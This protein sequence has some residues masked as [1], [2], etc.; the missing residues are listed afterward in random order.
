MKALILGGYGVFGGRL[1]RLLLRDG[2]D[3]FVGGR[4]LDKAAAFT[5]IHGGT[6]VAVDLARDLAPIS[7]AAPDIVVDAAG[8]FQSY[9]S[10]PY[11]VARFCL[12][13][14]IHYLDLSDDGPFTAG[15]VALEAEARQAGC[16]ALSGVSSVPAISSAAVTRLSDGMTQILVIESVILPGNRAPRGRSVVA[17]ILAQTGEPLAVWRGGAWRRH[18]AW[19][20]PKTF[21][22][23]RGD[24]RSARLIGAP[25]LVLF[26]QAFA[27]RSVIFR[28][29]LE[30]GVMQRALALLGYLRKHGV[31]PNLQILTVPLLWLSNLLRP[32]GTDR[33]G[34]IVTVTGMQQGKAVQRRWQVIAEAGDGPFVPAVPARSIIRHMSAIK[35]GARSCISELQL[36]DF[37]E[38]MSDLSVSFERFETSAPTLFQTALGLRW[39]GL[40]AAV[41]RLHSVQ[42]LESFSGRAGITRGRG[43]IARLTAWCFGFPSAGRNVRVTVTI[44]RN[45]AGEIWERDFGGR[46]FRSHLAP[47]QR[48]FHCHERFGPLT[49]ELELPVADGS[50]RLPVRRGWLMGIPLPAFLLPRSESREFAIDGGFHFDVGLYA[51]LTGELVVRYRGRLSPDA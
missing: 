3:V 20:E 31:L 26:P 30:L 23:R 17:S 10:D 46:R 43:L 51:P 41:Q 14:G 2:V 12:A 29:G 11:R 38:A 4:D 32:F 25:D 47:S 9:R 40:P 36:R 35:A 37:E 16:F 22:L 42:D 13:H 48:A 27:A 21:L 49:C 33:G 34:M 28:A 15:I 45:G 39:H 6:P 18:T 24:M 5:R 8:P 19:T 1:A 7:E 44:T 50:L